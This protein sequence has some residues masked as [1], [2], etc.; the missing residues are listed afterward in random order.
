VQYIGG[1]IL[2]KVVGHGAT[3][4][5]QIFLPKSGCVG[6]ACTSGDLSQAG[7]VIVTYADLSAIQ[8]VP[9]MP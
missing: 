4:V 6:S 9:D 7:S 2:Q 3:N 5:L 1:T 8:V